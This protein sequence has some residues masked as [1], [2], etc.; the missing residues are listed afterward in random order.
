MI[1]QTISHYRIVEKLG[2]GGMGVVYKAEDIDLGRFVALKFLPEDL[3][4]DPAAVNEPNTVGFLNWSGDGRYL[5]Y[6]S[7]FTGHPTFDR[8]KVGETH[9]EFVTEL[10]GLKR[11]SSFAAGPW[12]SVAPDGT[13]VFV[14]DLST[15]EIYALDLDLP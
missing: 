3:A 4:Q 10:K 15:D 9:P 1:D 13:P 8:V 14:R 6:D 7:P 12:S 11:Y 2:A 5:Y